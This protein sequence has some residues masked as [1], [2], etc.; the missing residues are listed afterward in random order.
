MFG[1]GGSH[2]SF[3]S[4]YDLNT[5]MTSSYTSSKSSI[6]VDLWLTSHR[7]PQP[8]LSI[9]NSTLDYPGN[10]V[11]PHPDIDDTLLPMG[12]AVMGAILGILIIACGTVG[13]LIN[14]L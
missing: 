2:Q 1:P 9:G 8:Q 6:D 5:S 11:A 10:Q 12:V 4:G 7:E 13:E 14:V 3:T